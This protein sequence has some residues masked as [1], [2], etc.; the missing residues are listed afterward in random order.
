MIRA[1]SLV[2]TC[3]ALAGCSADVNVVSLTVP[4]GGETGLACADTTTT[5]RASL[6]ERTLIGAGRA[7][8]TVVTDFL[9]VDGVSSGRPAG[10]LRFCTAHGCPVLLRDCREVTVEISPGL[11]VEG[12]QRVLRETLVEAGP[13]T[14]DAPDGVVVIRVV[15]TMQPCAEVALVADAEPPPF[16]PDALAGCLYSTPLQLDSVR[17]DVEL[18]LDALGGEC[19]DETVCICANFG[20]DYVAV[21]GL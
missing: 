14:T 8:A 2:V 3:V 19:T 1:S 11:G 10:L 7:A 13:V 15:L 6:G 12:V 9:A 18:E 17:G 4:P 16:E 21:C 5:D 20:Q